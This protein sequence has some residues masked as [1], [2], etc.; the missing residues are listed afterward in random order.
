MNNKRKALCAV[1]GLIVVFIS[2]VGWYMW[3]RPAPR[4]FAPGDVAT[5]TPPAVVVGEPLH[6]VDNGQFYEIDVTY[7]SATPLNASAG[8]AAD[9]AAVSA[10]KTFAEQQI[11]AFKENNGLTTMSAAEF[12]E[13]TFGR[14]AKYAMNMEY[15]VY[16]SPKTVSYVY[17]LYQDTMGAHPN[18]YYRTFTFDKASGESL[19]LDDLFAPGAPYL[20]RLSERTRADLPKIMAKMAE[21]TSDEVDHDYINSGTMPIADSFGNFALEGP[22]LLMIFPPYQVGPYVYGTITDPVPL[23]SLSSILNPKYRP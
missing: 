20:D 8:P 19:H 14:D 1:G 6:I 5:T 13:L 4:A 17:S 9:A 11:D 23:S 16:E 10:M 3:T 12:A 18:T 15:K 22:N 7:P 2:L 21:M